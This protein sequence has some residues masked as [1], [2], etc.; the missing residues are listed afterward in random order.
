MEGGPLSIGQ[1]AVGY[2]EQLPGKGLT[3]LMV[4]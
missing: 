1:K 3:H 2:M 4:T